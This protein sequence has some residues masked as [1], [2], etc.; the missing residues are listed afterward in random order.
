MKREVEI[1]GAS[2]LHFGL[3]G[4]GHAES[5]QFGG[6]GAMLETP[7][8]RL[9]VFAAETFSVH[10][11]LSSRVETFVQR[12]L[13]FQQRTQWPACSIDILETPP[14]HCGLGVGTQLGLAV[15]TAMNAWHDIPPPAPLELALSVERGLRSAVGTY[16]FLQGGFIAE[17]GKLPTEALAPLDVRLDFPADW[18][19]VLV[20]PQQ[21]HGIHGAQE[22]QAF[23]K[24]PP[25]PLAWTEQ[26]IALVRES[27]V[28]ALAVADFERFSESLYEYCHLAGSAFATVQG[29]A[30]HGPLLTEL[31]N[32][33]RSWGVAGV[34][35][36]SWGPTL[37]CLFPH[38]DSA[39]AFL[40]RVREE[41]AQL[42]LYLHLATP[43]NHG[44]QVTIQSS[45]E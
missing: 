21:L 7:Q 2:R 11:A 22:I 41:L 14:E 24:L 33:F 45:G 27:L 26:L 36:S 25:M 28:P 37:F 10:G 13:H 31:V 29:G 35:Q 15:A 44:V 5:R 23:A 17:R 42:D 3:Y 38:T 6:A 43:C 9:R 19:F 12:W 32:T 16:G 8:V 40:E 34:G 30:Y 1:R 39:K 4:F 18:R 20:T